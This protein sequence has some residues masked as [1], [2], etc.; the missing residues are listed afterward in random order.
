MRF[1]FLMGVAALS[2]CQGDVIETASGGDDTARVPTLERLPGKWR[3]EDGA[4]ICDGY[5]TRREHQDY[6]AAEIPADWQPM[7]FNGRIYYIQP[8]ART[9]R[10]TATRSG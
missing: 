2:G 8:L 7:E 10:E 1:P 4:M 6:C 3:Q 5:L 9:G